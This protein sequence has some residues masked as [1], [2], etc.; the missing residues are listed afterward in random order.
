MRCCI[1]NGLIF[2]LGHKTREFANDGRCCDDCNIEVV[3][4]LRI[5]KL[6]LLRDRRNKLKKPQKVVH[7]LEF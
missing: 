5:K 1:C 4:P 2:G 7:R 3:V 6:E